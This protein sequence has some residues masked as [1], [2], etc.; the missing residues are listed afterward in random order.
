MN[1][2]HSAAIICIASILLLAACGGESP[3]P[4]LKMVPQTALL[5][6]HLEDGLNQDTRSLLSESIPEFELADSLLKSGPVGV[7]LVGID[8]TSLEPQLLLL[9][10]DVTEQYASALAARQLDLDPR[11]EENRVDL[12]N[13]Q[14]YARASVA[15]R[16]GWT[17]IYLGPAP[18][19]TIGT[20][21][22]LDEDNSMAA[23]TALGSILPEDAHISVLVPGNLFGF[24]SFLPLERQLSWWQNYKDFTAELK[25]AALTAGLNWPDEP[26]DSIFLSLA[27]ARK[28]AGTVTI[29]VAA[30]NTG[31]NPDSA[32]ALVFTL[33]EGMS[34]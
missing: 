23:D 7:A 16:K 33:L 29:E 4:E 18:H 20:W 6:V 25:P 11:Q 5:L 26:G 34:L 15:E 22:D 3:V 31:M 17:A 13:Q 10:E 19:I 2:I 28:E 12:I 32:A 30:E 1:E 9:S 14:G 24:L 27:V 21:L 8:I